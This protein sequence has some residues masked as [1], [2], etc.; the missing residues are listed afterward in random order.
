MSIG[1][2]D[3]VLR[4]PRHQPLGDVILRTCRR[5]WPDCV[6]QDAGEEQIHSL[7]E[8]I[9]WNR[10]V[11]SKEFFVYRD[12]AAAEKWNVEGASPANAETM[13]YF[14]I[15]DAG[16]DTKFL[17]VTAVCDNLSPMMK[18]VVRDLGGSFQDLVQIA[19]IVE[20]A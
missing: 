4:A 16:N 20:A 1:G 2:T 5:H 14:I 13:L 12:R 11:A 9:V 19:S 6:F 17:E 10:G 3:V 7:Q 8:S 18:Q 15:D